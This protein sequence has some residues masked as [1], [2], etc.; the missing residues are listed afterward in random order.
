MT[1]R[2]FLE[3]VVALVL[4]AAFA[5]LAYGLIDFAGDWQRV[6]LDEAPR[7]IFT[8]FGVGGILWA[9]A[10]LI[11]N[12]VHRKRASWVK[13]VTNTISLLV[14]A[15][16]NLIAWVAF[17]FS[18][19]GW[20]VFLVAISLLASG[21]VFVAGVLALVVT[22]FVAFRTKKVDPGAAVVTN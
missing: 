7:A 12:L 20:A 5:I 22:H 21:F 6:F 19:G 9:I 3:T 8:G 15:I 11:G 2:A 14:A 17:G 13:F 18:M 10:L 4:T 16:V 1:L